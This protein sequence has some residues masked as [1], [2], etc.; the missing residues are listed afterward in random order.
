MEEGEVLGLESPGSRLRVDVEG[1]ARHLGGAVWL[2]RIA[3]PGDERDAHHCP[4]F[5]VVDRVPKG[6]VLGVLLDGRA[7]GRLLFDHTLDHGSAVLHIAAQGTGRAIPIQLARDSND[8]GI[9]FVVVKDEET[10][11]GAR[12]LDRTIDH[13]VEQGLQVPRQRDPGDRVQKDIQRA[14]VFARIAPQESAGIA[15]GGTGCSTR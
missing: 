5:E 4:Q 12:R 7:Q 14:R 10:A 8:L 13:V 3:A 11:L 9:G 6:E 1:A 2:A 15:R